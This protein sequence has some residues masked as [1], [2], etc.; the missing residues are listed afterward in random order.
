M[1]EEKIEFGTAR[2]MIDTGDQDFTQEHQKDLIKMDL[3]CGV[4]KKDGF[5]GIDCCETEH[6]DRVFD[7]LTFPWPIE[8]HSVYEFFCSHFVEHIPHDLHNGE[9][10]DGLM[11]FMDEVYRC[12]MPQG[13]ITILAPY[14]TSIRAWQDPTHCR[15]ITE[16]TWRYFNK[17]GRRGF[18]VDHYVGKAN[19]ELLSQQF[20]LDEAWIHRADE[21]RTWGMRHYWN[22][23]KDI[24]VTLRAVE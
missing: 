5:I 12:L 14:Y 19:F 21:A 20:I 18:G 23:V 6:T 24:Q 2:Q 9:R 15:A 7:L 4:G 11:Q 13:T 17:E 1:L 8:S 3:A 10:L 16:V 22:I